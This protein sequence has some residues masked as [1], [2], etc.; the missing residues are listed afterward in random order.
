VQG[1][2]EVQVELGVVLKI[3]RGRRRGI[4]LYLVSSGVVLADNEDF[5]AGYVA[6]SEDTAGL[7]AGDTDRK[8]T[9]TSDLQHS[10]NKRVR[11][12]SF[13]DYPYLSALIS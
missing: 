13:N 5:I 10:K 3:V 1:F 6:V 12:V 9:T 4:I 8:Q 11:R 7:G 2:V